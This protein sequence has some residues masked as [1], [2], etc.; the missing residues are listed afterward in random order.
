M[1]DCTS[2]TQHHTRGMAYDVIGMLNQMIYTPKDTHHNVLRKFE[3]LYMQS[4]RNAFTKNQVNTILYAWYMIGTFDSMVSYNQK[5]AEENSDTGKD[6]LSKIY[7]PHG[8]QSMYDIIGLKKKYQQLL[9]PERLK[10]IVQ[11]FKQYET[12]EIKVRTQ[13]E[14]DDIMYAFSHILTLKDIE[15]YDIK[16]SQWESLPLGLQRMI[17]SMEHAEIC[18]SMWEG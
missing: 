13:H 9:P 17:S 2:H 11:L 15:K 8:G 18:D 4:D 7:C 5:L 3:K 12:Y 14:M 6:E 10:K 1:A 16:I